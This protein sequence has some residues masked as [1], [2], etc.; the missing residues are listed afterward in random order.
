M[1]RYVR[2]RQDTTSTSVGMNG[3]INTN[4][5]KSSANFETHTHI[6]R[7]SSENLTQLRRGHHASCTPHRLLDTATARICGHSVQCHFRSGARYTL[8]MRIKTRRSAL[9]V[10]WV[11]K[12]MV[13]GVHATAM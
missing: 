11:M 13:S 5:K 2:L 6:R 7:D 8:H 1:W 12:H 10:T 3:S 4:A 9:V